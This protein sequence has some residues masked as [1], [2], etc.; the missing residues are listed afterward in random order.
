MSKFKS[1]PNK[2]YQTEDGMKW[3][4]RA[5]AVVANVWCVVDDIPYV[6]VGK[7]GPSMDNAGKYNMPCGYIDWDENLENAMYREVWEE[8]GLDLSIIP[9][10]SIS[11]K[12]SQQPFF[13][14][15]NPDSNRQNIT[16]HT[17]IIFTASKLPVL[18]LD[19]MEPGESVEARWMSEEEV[20]AISY[21][22]FAFKHKAKIDSFG[23]NNHLYF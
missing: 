23:V 15:T 13:V 10:D 5:C 21:D 9:S 19:N 16:L 4:S 3:D 14:D 17:G 11:Y 1:T 2:S 18:S 7:R 6:L 8:T 12:F 20:V 22:D